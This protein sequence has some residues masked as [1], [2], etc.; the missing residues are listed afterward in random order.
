MKKN[1]PIVLIPVLFLVFHDH[2]L[3]DYNPPLKKK[4]KKEDWDLNFLTVLD[5]KRLAR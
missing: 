1:L 4:N 2:Y 5:C 3:N